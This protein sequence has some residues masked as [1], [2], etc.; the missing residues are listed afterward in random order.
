MIKQME[1]F[2]NGYLIRIFS[3]EINQKLKYIFNFN[4][5][6]LDQLSN[7]YIMD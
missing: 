1:L 7:S 5:K 6:F 3:N 2:I 4:L